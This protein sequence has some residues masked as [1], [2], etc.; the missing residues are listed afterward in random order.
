MR[1][2]IFAGPLIYRLPRGNVMSATVDLVYINV[3]PE[4]ELSSS[5]RFVHFQKF[6]KNEVGHCFPQQPQGNNFCTRFEFLFRATC[7]S[8]LTF[9]TPLPSEI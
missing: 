2:V 1:I 4:Y 5:T 3:Q 8:D 6:E 7:A 9:L